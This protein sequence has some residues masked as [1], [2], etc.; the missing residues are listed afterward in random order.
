MSYSLFLDDIREISDV[1]KYMKLPD[2]PD[3]EWIIVR[4]YKEFIKT[5]WDKGIPKFVA[6]DHDLSIEQ[7][8]TYHDI[9]ET[10]RLTIDYDKFKEKTGYDCCKFLVNE[11][12]KLNVKHPDYV[13]HSMNPVGKSNIISYVESYNRILE[14]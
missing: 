8:E 1:R 10:G 9:D 3:D 11:C 7:Y 4:D 5:I 14:G 12:N 13:V 2:I 6:F